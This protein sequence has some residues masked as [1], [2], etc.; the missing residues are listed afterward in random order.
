MQASDEGGQRKRRKRG[1]RGGKC[2]VVYV[3][4]PTVI[5]N[6][7]SFFCCVSLSYLFL[8]EW[9]AQNMKERMVSH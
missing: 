4:C 6:L 9:E 5:T 3:G 8:E 7:I 1:E 2:V